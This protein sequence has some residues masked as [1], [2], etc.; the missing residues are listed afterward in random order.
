MKHLSE[1]PE[2]ILH[3]FAD[4]MCSW[5]WG[6]SPVIEAVK[7]RFDDRLAISFT[8]GG[9]RP[10]TKEPMD[11]KSKTDILYHWREVQ[12]VTG[13][14]F[15]FENA[16]SGHFIYDT[17]IPSRGLV[18]FAEI[19]PEHTFVFLKELQSAFYAKGKNITDENVLSEMASNF[20]ADRG[21]FLENFHSERAKRKTR[22]HF[23]KARDFGV[24]S[25]PSCVLQ[26]KRGYL[27]LS[28]G[29]RPLEEINMNIEEWL[30]RPQEE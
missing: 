6:F 25:F 19:F 16:M 29:Y 5:C 8:L 2:K 18:A 21:T 1:K 9:L 4:P 12:A 30:I 3:Y 15:L 14:P 27:P 23:L 26:D 28:T 7:L 20:G 10:Y 17:E 11:A 22:A 24:Q 13:Q